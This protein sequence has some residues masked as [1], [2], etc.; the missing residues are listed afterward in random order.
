[1]SCR[2]PGLPRPGWGCPGS[3]V[4][5]DQQYTYLPRNLQ[6][7]QIHKRSDGSMTPQS[8]QASRKGAYDPS[9]PIITCTGGGERCAE[10]LAFLGVGLPFSPRSGF[11][12]IQMPR[13]LKHGAGR[14]SLGTTCRLPPPLVPVPGSSAGTH[15]ASQARGDLTHGSGSSSSPLSTLPARSRACRLHAIPGSPP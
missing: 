15:P 6:N 1:M 7:L 9:Q 8:K 13:L 10:R 3:A 5:L 11:H 12:Q 2:C 4:S 14:P